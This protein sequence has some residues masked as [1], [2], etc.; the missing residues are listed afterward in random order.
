[1]PLFPASTNASYTGAEVSAG[2]LGLVGMLTIVPGCIHYFLPDGGAGVIAGMD[3]SQNRTVVLAMFAWMG[4]MQIPHGIAELAV[5]IWYRP[6]TP[7]FLL[8]AF[9][10]R[11]LM[12]YDG[13]LG[14][15]SLTGHHPPEHYASVAVLPL[16]LFFLALSLRPRG[17]TVLP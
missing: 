11:G 17:K 4:A 3:L 1:M 8:L 10:E 15:A 12:A 7:L 13:W 2:F 5:A 6:L 16:L 9:V 14:K